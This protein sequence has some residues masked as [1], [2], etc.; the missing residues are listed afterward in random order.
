MK[1][2]LFYLNMPKMH[3]SDFDYAFGIFTLLNLYLGIIFVVLLV[4]LF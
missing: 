1:P 3:I 4:N 2:A